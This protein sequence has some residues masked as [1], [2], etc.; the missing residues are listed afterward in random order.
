M[1]ITEFYLPKISYEIIYKTR[2][3]KVI[4]HSKQNIGDQKKIVQRNQI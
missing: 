2:Y 4:E 1:I 3:L